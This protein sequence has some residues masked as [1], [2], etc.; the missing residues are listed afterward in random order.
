MINKT[1]ILIVDD[2]AMVRFGLSRAIALEPDLA[3]IAEAGS[4]EEA[5]RLYEQHQTDVVVM[6]Y[7]LPGMDGVE[8]TAKLCARF[9][10]A[11]VIL[12]SIYEG[13]EDVWRATQSGALG[14]ISKAVDIGEVI[15]AIRCVAAGDPYFSEGLHE[16]LVQRTEESSLTGRELE[17]LRQVVLGR[18]N[19]EI[20]SLL[21]VTNSTIKRHM[22]SIFLKLGVV[23][24]T[25]ATSTALKRGIIHLS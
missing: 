24:R 9:P 23:D 11:R 13:S 3:L 12:L 21:E 22:E 25:Q 8:T 14:Y 2:H 19:K 1:R 18:S 10:Q 17:V 4:G 6:D 5:L 16:K 20:A 15:K 7:K